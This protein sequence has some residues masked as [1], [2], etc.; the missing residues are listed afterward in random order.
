MDQSLDY[1]LTCARPQTLSASARLPQQSLFQLPVGWVLAQPDAQQRLKKRRLLEGLALRLAFD[2]DHGA[3]A[4][5][6]VDDELVA[7]LQIFV[8]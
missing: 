1:G 6:P 8:F 4:G 3:G 7:R 2:G 5:N